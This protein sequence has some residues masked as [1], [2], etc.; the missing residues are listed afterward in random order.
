LLRPV[1]HGGRPHVPP[2]G[3][4]DPPY[5]L[6]AARHDVVGGQR[7]VPRGVPLRRELRELPAQRRLGR[8]DATAAYRAPTSTAGDAV[9][10]LGVPYVGRVLRASPPRRS[11]APRDDVPRRERRVLRGVPLAGEARVQR[12]ER[13]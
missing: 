8:G 10:D 7:P 13:G 4:A 1:P 9:V 3:G 11:A 6:V 12:G 2:A 5:P